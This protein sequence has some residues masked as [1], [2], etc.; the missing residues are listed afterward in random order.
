M[1]KLKHIVIT[2]ELCRMCYRMLCETAPFNT[3]NMPDSGDVIFS[4]TKSRTCSGE[5]KEWKNS[6]TMHEIMMSARSIGTLNNLIW[7]MAHEMIHLHQA[8]TK[9]RT[10]SPGV[11]HNRAFRRL[12]DVVCNHHHFDRHMFAEMD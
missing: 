6:D 1:P 5:Y 12:S 4:V 8:D 10:D 2:P 7:V 9:P 3:W 11:Q